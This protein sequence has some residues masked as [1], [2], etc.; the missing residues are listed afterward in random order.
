MQHRK[1]LLLPAQAECPKKRWRGR[2]LKI[3]KKETATL[4][5]SA[6]KGLCGRGIMFAL[7]LERMEFQ[8][9]AITGDK[10]LLE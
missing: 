5:A 6:E 8:Q 10:R 7:L 1:N 3:P 2:A 4:V 9:K